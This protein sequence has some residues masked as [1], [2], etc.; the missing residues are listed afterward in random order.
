MLEM[1]GMT[2]TLAALLLFVG[3]QQSVVLGGSLLFVYALGMGVLRRR[4]ANN[5]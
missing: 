3:T 5:Y 4:A 1:S 2:R